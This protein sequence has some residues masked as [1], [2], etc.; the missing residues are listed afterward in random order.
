MFYLGDSAAKAATQMSGQ[1]QNREAA[2]DPQGLCDRFKAIAGHPNKQQ[3]G[4]TNPM[5]L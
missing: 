1:G 2:V 5:V 3:P 4:N